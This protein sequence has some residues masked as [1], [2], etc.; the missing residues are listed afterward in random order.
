M[1]QIY[2]YLIFLFLFQFTTFGQRV[3]Q[4]DTLNIHNEQNFAEQV[5]VLNDGSILIAIVQRP[6][7]F[8]GK[9]CLLL[10]RADA[11]GKP[12]YTKKVELP[13]IGFV[14]VGGLYQT[15]INEYTIFCTL[16]TTFDDG[17]K[18][19]TTHFGYLKTNT[20]FDVIDFVYL[21]PDY[22][23]H[24]RQTDIIQMKVKPK[25]KD[26]FCGFLGLVDNGFTNSA[27]PYSAFITADVKNRLITF[28]FDTLHTVYSPYSSNKEFD[29]GISFEPVHDFFLFNN[30]ESI[31]KVGAKG[32]IIV[33][34]FKE[35]KGIVI[36]GGGVLPKP[37]NAPYDAQF[38]GAYNNGIIRYFGDTTLL[39][40]RTGRF[41]YIKD[42]LLRDTTYNNLKSN[43]AV[44]VISFNQKVIADTLS[45]PGY[46]SYPEAILMIDSVSQDTSESNF[47]KYA[48][49]M[50]DAKYYPGFK[51]GMDFINKNQIYFARTLCDIPPIE[52]IFNNQTLLLITQIDSSLRK[53]WEKFVI[54]STQEGI[55]SVNATYDGGCIIVTRRNAGTMLDPYYN[56]KLNRFEFAVYKFDKDG[57]YLGMHVLPNEEFN[58]QIKL[59]PNPAAQTVQL[60][61]A[62]KVQEVRCTDIYGI[63]SKLIFNENKQAY[64]GFLTPGIYF[65]SLFNAQ[66]QLINTIKLVKE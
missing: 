33:K 25:N 10:I 61:N 24:V 46:L 22:K 34:K 41:R 57:G 32:E 27:I 8:N 56:L 16:D 23:K 31:I 53:K 30:N 3:H 54:C 5:T 19:H 12:V 49:D 17:F 39:F 26:E 66:Q 7:L 35:N 9:G 58:N 59:Y 37:A 2:F 64:V 44:S 21:K 11:N 52:E 28:E 1:L 48:F 18:Y 40:A 29:L 50:C 62:D 43:A 42:L 13:K 45:Q 65:I 36:G 6:Y 14:L 55:V 20:N 38:I 63:T 4:Y 47:L 15:N 51:Q 60:E